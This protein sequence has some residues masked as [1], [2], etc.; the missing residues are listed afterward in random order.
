MTTG[1]PPLWWW[2]GAQTFP[3]FTY[4]QLAYITALKW[5]EIL[6]VWNFLL[7]NHDSFFLIKRAKTKTGVLNQLEQ[8][9]VLVVLTSLCPPFT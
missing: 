3:L 7:L 5:E 4:L 2:R 6:Y 9:Q 1:R 8:K